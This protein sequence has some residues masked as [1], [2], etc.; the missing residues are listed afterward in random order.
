MTNSMEIKLNS[1]L[2]KYLIMPEF[3]QEK[4]SELVGV[5]P[6]YIFNIFYYVLVLKCIS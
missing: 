5:S 4:L 6:D 2:K 1:N 3:S